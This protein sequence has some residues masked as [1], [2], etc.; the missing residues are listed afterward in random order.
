M[1]AGVEGA[2]YLGIRLFAD[3]TYEVW[4]TYHGFGEFVEAILKRWPQIKSG[5][6]SLTH[7]ESPFW[8]TLWERG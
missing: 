2:S 5:W 3:E 1:D 8:L 7:V 6:D 4:D